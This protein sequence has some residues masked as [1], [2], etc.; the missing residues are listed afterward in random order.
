VL[1]Q[2]CLPLRVLLPPPPL[3]LLLLM[4]WLQ[5]KHI[6]AALQCCLCCLQQWYL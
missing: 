3:L 5:A 1:Q 6:Q 2:S 4:A